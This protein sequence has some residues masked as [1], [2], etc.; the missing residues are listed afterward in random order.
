MNWGVTGYGTHT[1]DQINRALGTDGTGPAEVVLDEPLAVR[2]IDE[3]ANVPLK[4]DNSGPRAKVSMKFAGGAEVK[5]HFDEHHVPAF[6]AGDL[7]EQGKI[8]IGRNKIASNPPELAAAPD[9]PGPNR[10]LESTYH[11]ENWVE[12][13]KS[14]RRCTADVEIGQRST[15]LCYLVISSAK[16]AASARSLCWDPAAERF[17]NCDEGNHLLSRPRRKGY[18]LPEPG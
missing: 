18:E 13:I 11:I 17:T 6:G 10:R 9:N 3:T 8:E 2:A 1:Y 5:M 16:S 15:T 4:I 12:C 7:G 14:R